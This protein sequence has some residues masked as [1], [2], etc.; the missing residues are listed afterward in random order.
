VVQKIASF[1]KLMKSVWRVAICTLALQQS[2]WADE[3]QVSSVS[4]VSANAVSVTTPAVSTLPLTDLR[5]FV[6]V[7]ERI[8]NSYVDPVDDKTLFENAIKG[9]LSALDPHSAYLDK[10]DYEDLKAQTTGE[11]GGIGV[12]I[13]MEDGYL[14]VVSPIDDTP[15]SKAGIQAG[16]Y[17]TKLEGKVV[18]GMTMSDAVEIMRGAIGTPLKLTIQRKD[19]APKNI[20]LIRSKIEVSSVKS[21]TIAP[22]YVVVRISQFQTHTGRDLTAVLTKLKEQQPT[23]K[24][25]ILDLRNNPGGVLGGAINVADAFLDK[26][27]VVYTKART[28]ESVEKFEA[29]EGQV[30]PNIPLL[31]LVNGGSASASE[32]VAGAL[33]DHHR[34]II[35]GTTTF[36]KGS[37][38]TVLPIS[39]EKGIKLTTARYYTPNGRSIQAEGI[40]PDVVIEP[41]K[42]EI[43]KA[44]EG[45]KEADLK[46]HLVNPNDKAADATNTFAPVTDDSPSKT[47][48]APVVEPVS[49]D[50]TKKSRNKSKVK[51]VDSTVDTLGTDNK[52]KAKADIP[53]EKSLAE[54]DYVLYAAL[55]VLKGATFWQ[56]K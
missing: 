56:S 28:E 49:K 19:E 42:L 35:A 45:Y 55:N 41:A 34:A 20:T 51:P 46:G 24:G 52:D 15:A 1:G 25:I 22:D 2:V 36:G 50:S 48:A 44:S 39:A 30:L 33:Q 18:K 4:D 7:F 14:R 12:E 54:D 26:G 23:L 3:A 43:A 8:R 38:Q 29:T 17:I 31:V 40:K 37:V 21:R 47:E 11:F 16:D 5:T 6:D 27:L 32:I 13:G 9:M 53:T 10:N